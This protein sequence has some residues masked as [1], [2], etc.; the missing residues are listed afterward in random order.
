MKQNRAFSLFSKTRCTMNIVDNLEILPTIITMVSSIAKLTRIIKTVMNTKT[1]TEKQEN[2]CQAFI[3]L[4]DKSAA[5]R[6]A[7][8][9]TNM[10]AESIN[11][12]AVELFDNGNITARV[13][14]LQAEVKTR[15]DISID[16]IVQS[17]AGM[18]RFDIADLYDERGKLKPIHE[19]PKPARLMIQQ[20]D[21]DE[22]SEFI[23]GDKV[24]IGY[25]KK[26]KTYNKLEAVEKLM[27]HLGGYEKDNMQNKLPV[28][29]FLN[30]GEGEPEQDTA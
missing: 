24:H 17:L 25:T 23:A 5:Y 19:I 16:E 20:F 26:I 10:K 18:L 29:V 1:L 12:K 27:K 15:N 9:A 6:E 2:F 21:S 14:E 7:Y 3:R 13:K 11:R 28:N 22:I 30:L 4:G 8:S